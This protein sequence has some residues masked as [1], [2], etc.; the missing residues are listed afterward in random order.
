MEQ[1]YIFL[2]VTILTL[3][4]ET[5]LSLFLIKKVRKRELRKEDTQS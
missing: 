3:V 2:I 5:Y 1:P 4:V